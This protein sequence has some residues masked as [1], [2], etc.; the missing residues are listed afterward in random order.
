MGEVDRLALIAAPQLLKR[1][2]IA[3]MTLWRWMQAGVFPTPDLHINRRRYWRVAT[4]SAW[5]TEQERR[6]KCEAA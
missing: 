3:D 1:L 2:A 5:L 6:R 4:V